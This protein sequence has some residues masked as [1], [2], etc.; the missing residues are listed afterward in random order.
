MLVYLRISD[1][2]RDKHLPRLETKRHHQLACYGFGDALLNGEHIDQ[3]T[4]VG[5]APN[6]DAGIG[7]DQ[8]HSDTD[9]V[10]RAA[11]GTID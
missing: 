8:L 9:S 6:I 5:L 7:A 3:L 11:H 2:A 1:A 4:V 10:P